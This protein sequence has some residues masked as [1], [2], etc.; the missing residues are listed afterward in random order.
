MLFRSP[1]LDFGG[2]KVIDFGAELVGS[3]GSSRTLELSNPG[4]GLVEVDTIDIAEPAFS[5]TG[6]DCGPLPIQ[7]PVN[8]TQT[9][10]EEKLSV[11]WCQAFAMIRSD[12]I[13]MATLR[14]HQYIDSFR[15][16]DPKATQTAPCPGCCHSSR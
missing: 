12:F 1:V 2:M 13:R 4:T 16:S 3:T 8:A 5:I 7:I 15:S 11:R 10:R 6:G 9:A 14:V